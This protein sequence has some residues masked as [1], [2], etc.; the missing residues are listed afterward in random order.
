MPSDCIFCKIANKEIPI[1]A[2]Y[3]DSDFFAF[4]DIK[5]KATVH[6]V[7]IP[8]RHIGPHYSLSDDESDLIGKMMIVAG[9]IARQKGIDRS[10]YRL[11]MNS[12]PD[13]GMEV[14]HLHLH[15][16]G[17]NKLGPIA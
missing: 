16:L 12:G 3:E 10:G 13:S 17:G 6:I 4:T 14:D 5:S 8:K 2:V 9:V 11:V 1:E 7:L 15:I